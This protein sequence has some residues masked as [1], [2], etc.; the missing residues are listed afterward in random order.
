MCEKPFRW[1]RDLTPRARLLI[2]LY[3]A[4]TLPTVLALFVLVGLSVPAIIERAADTA[5]SG[6]TQLAAALSAADPA[7]GLGAAA[8]IL[9][10]LLPVVGL[11][12]MA[13]MLTRRLAAVEVIQH[14]LRGIVVLYAFFYVA[15]GGAVSVLLPAL[16]AA[17]A[18][19]AVTLDARGRPPATCHP[20]ARRLR[21][22][23]GF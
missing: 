22:R 19:V 14:V 7:G 3:A 20:A 10:A 4:V 23:R 5:T 12:F 8:R 11:G 9:L 21:E 2:R 18:L 17:G 15:L 6:S 1:S 13:V 16:V